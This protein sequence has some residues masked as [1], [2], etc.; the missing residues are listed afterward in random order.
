MA[1]E[2]SEP[3]APRILERL[4]VHILLVLG[5][6]FLGAGITI[7][8]L[9]SRSAAAVGVGAGTIAAAG[10]ISIFFALVRPRLNTNAEDTSSED[11]KSAAP[12]FHYLDANEGS[13][14]WPPKTSQR[15][16]ID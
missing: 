1:S 6:A 12:V 11:R 7:M 4:Y 14:A 3:S 15:S 8:G 10:F 5:V 2:P 16:V 9:A 13:R